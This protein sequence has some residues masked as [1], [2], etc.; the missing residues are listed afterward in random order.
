[1]ECDYLMNETYDQLAVEILSVWEQKK[2]SGASQIMVG[3]AAP[4]GAG[5]S[6]TVAQLCRRLPN[7]VSLPMDGYHHTKKQLSEF[8]DPEEAFR[9]RGAHWTFD[10]DG[11]VR[12][13]KKLRETGCG[14]FPSF[15]HAIGDPKCDDILIDPNEHHIVL[16]EGNYLLLD[17]TPWSF[18]KSLLDV[19]Y[20]IDCDY[21]VLEKRVV[22][23]HISVGRTPEQAQTRFSSNDGPN[24]LQ[25][26]QD[27][28]R[29][30]KIIQ[31]K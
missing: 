16:I 29:A 14:S 27:K 21:S 30:D 7:S 15:D 12:D 10:A 1:M 26:L 2:A 23:R 11:F 17:V 6:T 19:S 5:K 18:I 31:S 25:I 20:F 28:H 13:L 4:P 8:E 22:G 3:F 9:R 24:A